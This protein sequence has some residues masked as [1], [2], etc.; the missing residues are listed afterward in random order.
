MQFYKLHALLPTTQVNRS[1]LCLTLKTTITKVLL[2]FQN[3]SCSMQV[4][5][6]P[7]GTN[8]HLFMDEGPFDD[9]VLYPILTKMGFSCPDNKLLY[10]APEDDE[11]DVLAAGLIVLEVSQL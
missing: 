3:L 10:T 5:H 4:K 8:R 1:S 9:P 11:E 6:T 2:T 7:Y